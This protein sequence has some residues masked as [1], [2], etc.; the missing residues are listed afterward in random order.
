MNRFYILISAAVLLLAQACNGDERLRLEELQQ[1]MASIKEAGASSIPDA[2]SPSSDDPKEYAF[3]FDRNRYGVDAGKSVSVKYTLPEASTV[4]VSVPEGWSATVDNS[5]SEIII[6]APDPAS[7][8][9]VV[10]T[11]V[12]N[13]GKKTAAFVPVMVRDPYSD[14]TRPDYMAM[15]YYGFKPQ[16][17]TL[18]NFQKL[19]DAG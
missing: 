8:G 6:S 1:Q 19:A 18:E 14:A 15:G 5:I 13:D 2:V 17:A 10:A 12:S 16:W 9:Q 7:P 11:A 3:T 4:E